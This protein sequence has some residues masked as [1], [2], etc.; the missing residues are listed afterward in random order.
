LILDQKVENGWLRFLKC[1]I[2]DLESLNLKSLIETEFWKVW[3]CKTELKQDI[4]KF[5]NIKHWF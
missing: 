4:E 3:K 1:E 2:Y 5:K